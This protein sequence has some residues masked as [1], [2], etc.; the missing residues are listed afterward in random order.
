M[1]LGP[2]DIQFA[3]FETYKGLDRVLRNPTL[4]PMS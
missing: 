2:D 1:T 3:L 4:H